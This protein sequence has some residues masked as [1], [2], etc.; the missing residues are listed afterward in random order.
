MGGLNH[1]SEQYSCIGCGVQIQT[2][3]PE[4]LGYAPTS[5]LQKETLSVNV[6]FV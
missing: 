3:N 6:V 4:E 2:E 5:A 1:L